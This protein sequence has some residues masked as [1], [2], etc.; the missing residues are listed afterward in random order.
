MDR[1][2]EWLLGRLDAGPRESMVQ[3]SPTFPKFA[4]C[5]SHFRKTYVSTCFPWLRE[6]RRRLT[7]RRKCE[8]WKCS[9]LFARAVT[10]AVRPKQRERPVQLLPGSHTQ[11]QAPTFGPCPWASVPYLDLFC[12]SMSKMCPPVSEKFK[13]AHKGVT[14][15]VKRHN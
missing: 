3:A 8:K 13:R 9:A 4:L 7:F 12:V 6:I 10:E 11:H 15:S 1:R 2:R 5:T 14:L